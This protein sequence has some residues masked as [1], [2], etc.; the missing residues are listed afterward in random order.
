MNTDCFG[1]LRVLRIKFKKI[2]DQYYRDE[3]SICKNIL[4][5][6]KKKFCM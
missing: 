6:K 1:D 4:H 3:A 5:V 2:T